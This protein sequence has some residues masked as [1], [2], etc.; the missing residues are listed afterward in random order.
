MRVVKPR[1]RP[2]KHKQSERAKRKEAGD[3]N[4]RNSVSMLA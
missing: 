1:L 3:G 4:R 2:H